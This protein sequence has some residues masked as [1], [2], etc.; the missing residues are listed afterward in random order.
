M[1]TTHHFTRLLLG[2][3]V[4]A[5]LLFAVGCDSSGSMSD[6]TETEPVEGDFTLR[7]TDAPAD[8]DSAVVTIDR[9]DLVSEDADDSDD[10]EDGDDDGN[11]ED[12]DGDDG[13]D[14]N[15]DDDGEEEDGITTLTDSTRQI[16]L[17]QLQDGTT[18]LLADGVTVPEG[19]Y[20]QLRFVLTDDVYVI[21]NGERE[22]LMVPSNT[23]RIV[24][25]DVEVQNDGDQLDVTL[26]FDVEDSFVE[27]GNGSYLFKPKIKV[28]DVRVNGE[29][30][31]TVSV[32]GLVTEVDA[33]N[34]ALSVEGVP[35]TVGS[36][37]EY[38]DLGSLSAFSVD[39]YVSV[40]GTRLDNGTLEA[41]E[42]ET[43]EQE[44]ERSV[45]APLESKTDTDSERS[46]TLLGLTI[47][48]DSET[49]FDDDGGFDTLSQGDR[50][51]VEYTENA[52]GQKVATEIENE[53]D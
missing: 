47:Q 53:D 42:V 48:V 9:V 12:D 28:K 8:L 30:V 13:D 37:T 31:E 18:A 38:G 26:D 35:F 27:Q 5:G 1:L 3:M 16:D 45:T 51:E 25:P 49:E 44:D 21:V 10:G 14:D 32:E 33:S 50:V 11:D 46:V 2:L 6:G 52:D 40:E 22:S 36:K 19:E 17:L 23:I 24:L 20:A 39:Q 29:A 43:E 41:R 15:G 7:L 34:D 4:G